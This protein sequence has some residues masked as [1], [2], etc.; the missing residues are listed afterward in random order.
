MGSIKE[1]AYTKETIEFAR[2]IKAIAHPARI[3]ILDYLFK[4]QECVCGDF[5]NELDLA[6]ATISRHLNEL[7]KVGLIKGTIEGRNVCY[8][9]NV[10]NY[11]RFRSKLHEVF[12]QV[13]INYQCC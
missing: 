8:C 3:M 10:S 12:G 9:I 1:K 2:V 5:V 13:Q 11:S 7:K 4:K 6:Q